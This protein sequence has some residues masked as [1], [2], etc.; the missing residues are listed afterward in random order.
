MLPPPSPRVQ[1][2]TAQDL[3]YTRTDHVC[4]LYLCKDV[5]S[6]IGAP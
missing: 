1:F 2:D 3:C 4:G 6:I 5:E